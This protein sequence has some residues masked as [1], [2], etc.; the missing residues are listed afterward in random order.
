LKQPERAKAKI[1]NFYCEARIA[2]PGNINGWYVIQAI[3]FYLTPLSS[4]ISIHFN[5]DRYAPR[6]RKRSSLSFVNSSLCN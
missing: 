3:N 2:S 1:N 4:S 5:A 6:H